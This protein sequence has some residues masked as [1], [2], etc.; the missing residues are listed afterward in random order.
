MRTG[1]R[2]LALGNAA[3][4]SV[5]HALHDQ[6]FVALAR[7]QQP[8]IS[9]STL[10]PARHGARA[11]PRCSAAQRLAHRQSGLTQQA[12]PAPWRDGVQGNF[13]PP[14]ARR[15]PW[16]P[17]G[18]RM[19][20]DHQQHPVRRE[21]A[22][23]LSRQGSR[24]HSRARKMPDQHSTETVVAEWK[25]YRI[26]AQRPFEIEM[27]TQVQH[28]PASQA[29]GLRCGLAD[30]IQQQGVRTGGARQP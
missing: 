28:C 15:P 25:R 1:H 21:Y 14:S 10:Q 12:P 27:R 26:R 11:R 29:R 19:T 20:F 7:G 3:C 16:P 2:R 18:N 30:R 6:G 23:G 24:R 5:L 13:S 4:S 22:R 8:S 9:E 17:R